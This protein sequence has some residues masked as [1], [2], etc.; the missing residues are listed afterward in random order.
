MPKTGDGTQAG[1]EPSRPERKS[2]EAA[3]VSRK[4][5]AKPLQRSRTGAGSAALRDSQAARGGIIHMARTPP[6]AGQISTGKDAGLN[7]GNRP[8]RC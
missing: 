3:G 8:A 5:R 6:A 7:L 4:P 1:A 2:G